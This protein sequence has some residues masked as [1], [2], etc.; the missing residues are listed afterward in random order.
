MP[1]LDSAL[2]SVSQAWYEG[3]HLGATS[4]IAH[5]T[6]SMSDCID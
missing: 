1:R 2:A 5:P 3:A 6:D 4:E